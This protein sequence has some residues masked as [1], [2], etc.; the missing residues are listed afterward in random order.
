MGRYM[1][2]KK[3][4]PVLVLCSTSARTRETLDLVLAELKA[5]P[6][7]RHADALYL[8]EWP[9]LLDAVRAAPEGTTPLL[10]VGHNPGMEQ[11]AAA[12]IRQPKTDGRRA[13][14]QEMDEKFPTGALA[15]IDFRGEGW[16]SV[17]PGAGRLKNFVRPK[18]LTD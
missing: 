14:A 11:L 12:L 13:L 1:R 8:A 7:I 6:E 9:R 15:V 2:V 3:Y 18:D 4:V 5:S 10:L 17:R 16:E